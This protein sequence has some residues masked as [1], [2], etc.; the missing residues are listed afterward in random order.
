MCDPFDRAAGPRATTTTRVRYPETDRMGVAH[1]SHYLVWFELA[2]TN[3]CT[4]SGFHYA[5]IERLGFLLMV[6]GAE[7]RYRRGARYGDKLRVVAW[8]ARLASR[9]LSFSYEVYRQQELLATGKTE[10]VWVE[11]ESG[12]LCRTPESL[13]EP[14]ERLAGR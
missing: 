11:A 8:V 12:R 10:H 7:A 4:V 1:H 2:R 3:L 5:D 13:R 6:T 14:F 9:G